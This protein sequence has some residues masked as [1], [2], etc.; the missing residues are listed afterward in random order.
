MPLK[1]GKAPIPTRYK[2]LLLMEK[3]VRLK[4]RGFVGIKRRY[5]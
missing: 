3:I 2:L 1:R 5:K 4:M